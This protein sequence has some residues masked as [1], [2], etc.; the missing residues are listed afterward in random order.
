M[1]MG[2]GNYIKKYEDGELKVWEDIF[3]RVIQLKNHKKL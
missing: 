1:I 3:I 2:P